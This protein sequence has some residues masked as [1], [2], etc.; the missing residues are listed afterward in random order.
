MKIGKRELGLG[1]NSRLNKVSV[2]TVTTATP[3]GTRVVG[4]VGAGTVEVMGAK[5]AGKG[6]EVAIVKS[7]VAPSVR[8]LE[9]EPVAVAEVPEEFEE[10]LTSPW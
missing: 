9:L 5:P 7:G 8:V 3:T 6:V 10:G 4:L 2:S 1:K